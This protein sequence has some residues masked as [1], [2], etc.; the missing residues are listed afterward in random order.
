M[1]LEFLKSSTFKKILGIVSVAGTG[2]AAVIGAISDQKKESE[3]EEM[4]KAL[5]ELQK[6]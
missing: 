3:F 1:N 4:K 2:V 5:E 6:K